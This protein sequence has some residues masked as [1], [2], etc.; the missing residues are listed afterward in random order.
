ML[1]QFAELLG[2]FTL[3]VFVIADRAAANAEMIQELLRVTRVFA[4]DQINF[5]EHAQRALRDVFQVANRRCDNEERAGHAAAHCGISNQTNKSPA[6]P[7]GSAGP[8][9]MSISSLAV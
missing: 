5:A 3:V 9:S 7:K 2:A 8:M 4:S 1:E 6:N